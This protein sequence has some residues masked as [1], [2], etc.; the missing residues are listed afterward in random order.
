[1]E[2]YCVGTTSTIYE[3]YVLNRKHQESSESVDAYFTKLRK[4]S[5]TCEFGQIAD[6]MI[7]DRIVGGIKDNVVRKGYYEKQTCRKR[8]A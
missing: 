3:R 8:T 6:Q 4:I 1:M 2:D 5:L 7:R